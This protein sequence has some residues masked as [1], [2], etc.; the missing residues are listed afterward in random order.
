MSLMTLEQLVADLGNEPVPRVA[1]A[2]L[3]VPL[4]AILDDDRSVWITAIL[5]RTAVY[6]SHSPCDSSTRQLAGHRRFVV[7]SVGVRTA[8]RRDQHIMR[9]YAYN[10][11]MARLKN[12]RGERI[13]DAAAAAQ[14][15]INSLRS[16]LAG[17]PQRGP[18]EEELERLNARVRELSEIAVA[19]VR[20][21]GAA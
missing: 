15:Q 16:R 6:A 12:S 4:P 18:L 13:K 9:R 5:D 7:E 10:G 3:D 17:S 1:L 19:P 21:A 8:E 14:E 11:R 2:S 20:K